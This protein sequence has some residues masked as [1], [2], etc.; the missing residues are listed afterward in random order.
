[1]PRSRRACF[2]AMIDPAAIPTLP[3]KSVRAGV[4]NADIV[5]CHG[6]RTLHKAIRLFTSSYWNHAALAMW[7][8]DR[9]VVLE[10]GEN[11]TT[12]IP[13]SRFVERYPGEV[14]LARCS[15]I[16]Y[17]EARKIR[18]A[19]IDDLGLSY[20]TWLLPRLALRKT[21]GKL[22]YKGA[23]PQNDRRYCSE[24]VQAAF[25]VA[26]VDFAC[27]PQGVISPGAIADHDSV[28]GIGRLV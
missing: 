19:A 9:L 11:G 15:T 17:L 16:T 25:R 13:L 26:G 14:V 3:Y 1:M 18:Q 10:A 23:Q 22:G 20:D 12:T 5:L 27:D 8:A 2:D 6:R 24:F 21:L 7:W 4:Q 28:S